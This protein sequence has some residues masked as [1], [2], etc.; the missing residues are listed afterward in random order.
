MYEYIKIKCIIKKF[1]SI[2]VYYYILYNFYSC[3][4]ILKLNV[5]FN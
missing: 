1:L 4:N 2:L 3:M 5:L